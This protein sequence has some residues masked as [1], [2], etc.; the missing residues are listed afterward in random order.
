MEGLLI[1]FNKNY[2][3]IEQ[4]KLEFICALLLKIILSRMPFECRR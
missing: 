4:M 2:Y 1:W 3:L